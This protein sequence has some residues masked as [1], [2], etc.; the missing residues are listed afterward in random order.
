MSTLAQPARRSQPAARL[1]RRGVVASRRRSV[2]RGVVWIAV[3]AVLLAGV[4]AVNVAVLQLNVR[5]DELSRERVQLRYDN[6]G[7]RAQLSSGSANARIARRA[8]GELGLVPAD[9]ATTGYVR[10]PARP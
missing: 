8:A 5:L 2:D 7:L 1:R 9:S 6:A 3:I 4:V 10:L